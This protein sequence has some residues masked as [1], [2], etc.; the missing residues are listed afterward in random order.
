MIWAGIFWLG[1][2]YLGEKGKRLV[3]LLRCFELMICTCRL[4]VGALRWC[5]KV[6]SSAGIAASMFDHA[7]GFSEKIQKWCGIV[8]SPFICTTSSC[9][10]GLQE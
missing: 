1:S 6:L 7:V 2:I 9:G 3:W 4:H 8:K 5:P 10:G